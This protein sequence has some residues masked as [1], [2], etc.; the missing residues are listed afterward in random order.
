MCDC[1]YVHAKKREIF[2]TVT[3]IAELAGVSTGTVDRVVHN[4]G[5]VSQETKDKINKIISEQ[6]YR[7]D[8]IARFLKKKSD[9]KIGVLIPAIS[10]ESGYWKAIYD[11]ILDSCVNDYAAFGFQI[12]LFGFKRP[13]SA[14]LKSQFH[15]MVKY[16]CQAYIIAP[17]MQEEIMFLLNEAKL[18]AP[19]SFI[20]SPLPGALPLCTVA[21]NPFKAG[22]LAG[23]LTRLCSTKAGTYAV[24]KPFSES[25]NLNERAH[26]FASYFLQTS[27]S[28][29]VQKIARGSTQEDLY[30]AVEKIIDEFDDLRGICVVNSEVHYAGAKIA[31]LGRKNDISIVGF[32]LVEQ[33]VSG[34]KN[35]RIDALISQDPLRQGAL[36][37][38]EIYKNLVLEKEVIKDVNIPLNILFKENID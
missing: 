33:N 13:D 32:D 16:G 36:I 10:E 35:G 3:E 37:M 2:L 31:E 29:A 21:Q 25:Y 5:R 7:P 1:V 19:Y 34:L 15:K 30:D 6:G 4:R 12:E 24:I 17:I 22:L 18:S 20:D 26:G 28:R 23:K 38:K 11:G 9:F 14:S 8:P 27:D